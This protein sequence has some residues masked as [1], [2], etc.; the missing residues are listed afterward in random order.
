MKTRKITIDDFR[1]LKDS[2]VP[3][4]E[5]RFSDFISGLVSGLVV[6]QEITGKADLVDELMFQLE[7]FCDDLWRDDMKA[8]VDGLMEM[9]MPDFDKA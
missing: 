8:N 1:K 9:L 2:M 4:H 3:E 6:A 5:E 7:S